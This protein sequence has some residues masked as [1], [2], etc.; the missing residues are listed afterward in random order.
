[1]HRSAA[2]MTEVKWKLARKRAE[3][4][5]ITIIFHLWNKDWGSISAFKKESQSTLDID[6]KI[7]PNSSWKRKDTLVGR[8]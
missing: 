2:E 7:E 6:L 4:S 3:S 8:S 1:M 5:T